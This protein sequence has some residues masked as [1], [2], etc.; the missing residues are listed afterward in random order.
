MKVS[1]ILLLKRGGGV[2]LGGREDRFWE[3]RI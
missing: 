1:H 3:G 2:I